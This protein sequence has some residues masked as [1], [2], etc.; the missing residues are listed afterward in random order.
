MP[1]I[2]TEPLY[3]DHPAIQFSDEGGEADVDITNY[4]DEMMDLIFLFDILAPGLYFNYTVVSNLRMGDS[5]GNQLI[6]NPQILETVQLVETIIPIRIIRFVVFDDDL[7]TADTVVEEVLKGSDFDRLFDR[8]IP[9]TQIFFDAL[10]EHYHV[11]EKLM[12]LRRRQ[13]S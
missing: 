13:I 9:F 2:T 5:Q 7:V 1:S 8:I 11:R 6:L 12:E 10:P 3:L 4:N